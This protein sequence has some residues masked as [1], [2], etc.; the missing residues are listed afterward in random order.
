MCTVDTEP[1][2]FDQAERVALNTEPTANYRLHTDAV[3][4]GF[5]RFESE[6]SARTTFEAADRRLGESRTS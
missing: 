2:A 5:D 1:T 6:Q 3:Q 4:V